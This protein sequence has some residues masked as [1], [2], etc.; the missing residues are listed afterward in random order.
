M[1][2]ETRKTRYET[3]TETRRHTNRV[4]YKDST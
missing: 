2:S 4:A 1:A 3:L